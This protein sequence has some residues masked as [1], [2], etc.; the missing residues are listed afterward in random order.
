MD[1]DFDSGYFFLSSTVIVRHS[2]MRSNTKTSKNDIH[3]FKIPMNILK[4]PAGGGDICHGL[5][6]CWLKISRFRWF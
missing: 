1:D 3:Y 2:L 4:Y 5:D 6:I